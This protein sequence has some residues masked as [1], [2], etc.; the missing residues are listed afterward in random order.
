MLARFV[1]TVLSE[2]SE[3][4]ISSFLSSSLTLPLPNEK[5]INKRKDGRKGRH[6]WFEMLQILNPAVTNSKK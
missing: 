3:C 6:K 2:P 1:P 5:E 4:Y